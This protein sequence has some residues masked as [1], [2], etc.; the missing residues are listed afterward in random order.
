MTHRAIPTRPIG[1]L[2]VT[3]VGLGTNNFGLRLDE[4]RSRRVVDA[5]LEAGINFFDTADLYGDSELHIGRA[6]DGRRDRVVL[7]TKFGKPVEGKG[8]GA[9]PEYVK[10][11]LEMS[12]DRLRTDHVDLYQIHEPDLSTPIG[13]TLSALNDLVQAGKVKEIGCS[14]FSVAQ[15]REAEAAAAKG[16]A[17]F[18]SVQNEYSLFKRGAEADVLPECERTGMAFLPFFPLASG[19]LTGKYRKGAIPGSGSRLVDSERWRKTL[20]EENLERVERLVG[21]AESRGHS[22]L[23]LAFGYL[24]ASTPVSSVIAGATTPEQVFANADAAGWILDAGE[25]AE[26]ARLLD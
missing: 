7:A 26:V 14:N 4:D 13:E 21:Y 17:R 12:L 24:L 3:I 8:S 2:Q 5:A 1:S 15:L 10:K 6:L 22:L 18:V 9:R 25:V 23:E 16:A 20:T 11:A 19:L